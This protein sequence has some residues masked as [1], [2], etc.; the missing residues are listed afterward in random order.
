MTDII[1]KPFHFRRYNLDDPED[2]ERLRKD[3][4]YLPGFEAAWPLRGP[5]R[6]DK[7]PPRPPS[8]GRRANGGLSS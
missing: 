1:R 2:F 7:N 6:R 4:V 8:N 5:R 3:S